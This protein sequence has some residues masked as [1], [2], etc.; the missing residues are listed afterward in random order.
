VGGNEM[1][2]ELDEQWIEDGRMYKA[3]LK[4]SGNYISCSW[5][6]LQLAEGLIAIDL[7]PV[8]EDGCLRDERTLEFPELELIATRES[9]GE[10]LWKIESVYYIGESFFGGIGVTTTVFGRTEQE[11]KDAWNRRAIC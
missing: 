3:I 5:T 2:H 9:T 7:G 4:G 11:C 8:N 1:K 6:G 10:Q